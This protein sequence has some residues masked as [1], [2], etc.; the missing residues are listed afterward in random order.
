[1]SRFLSVLRKLQCVKFALGEMS[2]HM[3][4][5][6]SRT[7]ENVSVVFVPRLTLVTECVVFAFFACSSL[8]YCK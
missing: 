2:R 1:M 8:S 5:Y 7:M 4:C 6:E 3:V